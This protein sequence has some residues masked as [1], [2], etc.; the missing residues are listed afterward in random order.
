MQ[1]IPAITLW[2]PWAS[3]IPL[4]LK[5]NETRNWPY[6]VELE[7]APWVAIHAAKAINVDDETETYY[8]ICAFLDEHECLPPATIHQLQHPGALPRGAVVA[9]GRLCGCLRTDEIRPEDDPLEYAFGNYGPGRYAWRFEA[10]RSLDR[11]MPARG[12]QRFWTWT[13]PDDFDVDRDTRPVHH[14]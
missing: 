1:P 5:R 13:P 11:A 2:Q 6:P 7:A 12:H 4:G 14:E 10:L 8:E 3:A 9:L